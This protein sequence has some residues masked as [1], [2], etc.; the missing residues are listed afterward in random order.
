M[1]INDA[2][3]L[4]YPST[5]RTW[6][7][8]AA[9]TWDRVALGIPAR[10][11]NGGVLAILGFSIMPILNTTV[12]DAVSIGMDGY[13]AIDA[14]DVKLVD[15]HFPYND[16]SGDA[17][18][19][20]SYGL[21]G[22]ELTHEH[23][24]LAIAATTNRYFHVFVP[25]AMPHAFD[26][27][28]TAIPADFLEHI[29]IKFP[30][31]TVFNLGASTG[32]IISG[33][34]QIVTH[35]VEQMAIINPALFTVRTYE[36]AAVDSTEREI[37]TGGRLQDV[38]LFS[39][40]ASGGGS[41][42]NVTTAQIESRHKDKFTFR[43]LK[44]IYAL[45]RGAANNSFAATGAPLSTDPFVA[46]ENGTTR[47]LALLM[48]TGSKVT[49][50]PENA[51]E[52]I[53]LELG[54]SLPAKGKLVV[55]YTVPRSDKLAAL[56]MVN[57]RVKSYRYKTRDKTMQNPSEWTRTPELQAKALYMPQKWSR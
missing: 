48:S 54:G 35:C 13:R 43:A 16:V 7:A 50:G 46:A 42:A 21:A 12:A 1:K 23:Q 52:V 4:S 26:E 20:A 14:L 36:L 57:H 3:K 37:N 31:A 8:G 30:A 34:Y 15:G 51:K 49:D 19:V 39:P 38:F 24:D 47:A 44:A 18:R 40:G 9:E 53:R 27:G 32:S 28:D 33:Q 41:L 55:R 6:I 17:L 11:P 10:G 29:R 45:G 56:L 22:A 2:A 25:L 5:F